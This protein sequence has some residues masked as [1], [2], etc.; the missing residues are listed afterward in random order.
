VAFSFY[1]YFSFSIL[2]VA[3]PLDGKVPN[4]EEI[5]LLQNVGAIHE[6]LFIRPVNSLLL[7]QFLFTTTTSEFTQNPMK[8]FGVQ[9]HLL[10]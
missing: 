10:L 2:A 1:V 3:I 7:H 5:A 4:L 6:S 8:S 9:G